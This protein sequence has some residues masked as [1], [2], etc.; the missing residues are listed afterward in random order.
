MAR[1][2]HRSRS[3][4]QSTVERWKQSGLTAREFSAKEGVSDRTL[5]WWSSTLRRG[6]R[7]ERGSKSTTPPIPV[8]IEIELPRGLTDR[9]RVEIAV[10]GL[11]VRAEV[12]TDPDYLGALCLA[13]G[14]RG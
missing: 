4:W 3:W 2:S 14:S 7:A 12:G 5:L 13:L 6:T 8:P 11:V 10:G 1:R 9:R